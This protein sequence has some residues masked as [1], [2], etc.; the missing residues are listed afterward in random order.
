LA[1]SSNK[2]LISI[3]KKVLKEN[4]KSWCFMGKSNRNEEIYWYFTI[5]DGLWY[6]CGITHKLSTSCNETVAGW[7]R[8][9]Q[10]SY[11]K[12]KPINWSSTKQSWSGWQTS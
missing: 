3:I 12:N 7:E 4:K 2:I 8:R 6:R 5:S 1:E 10:S 9:A 11:Q